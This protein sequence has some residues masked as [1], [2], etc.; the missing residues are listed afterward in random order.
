MKVDGGGVKEEMATVELTV[1]STVGGH[2]RSLW[3][4]VRAYYKLILVKLIYRSTL[5]GRD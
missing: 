2:Q 5:P 4:F 1:Q 3:Y